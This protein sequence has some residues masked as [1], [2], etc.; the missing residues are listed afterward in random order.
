MLVTAV[1]EEEDGLRG[2]SA[3]VDKFMTEVDNTPNIPPMMELEE[4]SPLTYIQE[5][6]PHPDLV[7][8][9]RRVSPKP[10]F[11]EAP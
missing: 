8:I 10:H 1:K 6:N 3:K 4:P 9:G 11:V 7:V 5:P 2:T